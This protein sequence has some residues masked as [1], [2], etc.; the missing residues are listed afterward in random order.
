MTQRPP[1]EDIERLNLEILQAHRN[2]RPAAELAH[3]YHRGAD[4]LL[5]A[6]DL[7]AALFCCSTAYVFALEAGDECLA[8]N[9]HTTLR[10]HGRE[11]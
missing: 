11:H 3:L 9:L 7:D 1:V 8:K 6:D 10:E 5:R 4:L 2:G